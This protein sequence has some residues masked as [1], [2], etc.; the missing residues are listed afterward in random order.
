MKTEWFRKDR[1]S[2]LAEEWVP[3]GLDGDKA[4]L[5]LLARED[6]DW[7]PKCMGNLTVECGASELIQS[8]SR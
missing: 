4:P 2:R 6:G 8:W 1:A 3:I 7:F 5:A